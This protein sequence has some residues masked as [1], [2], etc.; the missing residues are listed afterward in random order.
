MLASLQRFDKSEV[1]QQRHKIIKFYDYY[2]EAATK[3]A[4]GADRKIIHVWKK[5]LAQSGGKLEALVPAS[6]TPSHVR[7]MAV[8]PHIIDFI[9][10]YRQKYG[11]IGKEKLKPLLDPYCKEI[12]IPTISESKIGKI[13]KRHHFFSQGKPGRVY[14][15]P[16]RK[17]PAH[18]KRQRVRKSPKPIEPGHIQTDSTVIHEVGTTRYLISAIDVMTKFALTGCY[19]SLSSRSATDFLKRFLLVCPIPIVSVQSDNGSEFLG[20]FD[21]ELQRQKLPHYFSYPHCPKINS[22]I[23]RYNRTIKAEFVAQ[24]LDAIHNSSLFRVR[25]AQYLIFYNCIRPHKSLDKKSPS[26]ALIEKGL[27]SNKIATST[28]S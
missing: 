14:H 7:T 18:C 17:E 6:T 10:S 15:D 24:N 23:E 19:G 12:G 22:F 13:I 1:A 16:G 28:F 21:K 4:F 20:D 25:L 3:E 8:D 11:R 26:Q 2:G 5:K 27:M 9:R